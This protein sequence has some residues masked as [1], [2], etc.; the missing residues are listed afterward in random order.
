MP[1]NPLWVGFVACLV[2]FAVG[3][4][5]MPYGYYVL[6]RTVACAVCAYAC[7]QASGRKRVGWAWL[8]GALAVLYNPLVP[9]HLRSKMIWALV[10]GA[11][12]AV[13]YLAAPTRGEMTSDGGVSD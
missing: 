4:L 9:I 7:I 12:L 3:L 8:F 2:V 6:S 5:W 1:K 10:N 13:L 11:T